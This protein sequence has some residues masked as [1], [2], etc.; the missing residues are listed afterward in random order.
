MQYYQFI[1]GMPGNMYHKNYM[2]FMKNLLNYLKFV[3][4]IMVTKFSIFLIKDMD[5]IN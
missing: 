1:Y 2:S 5:R 4:M 3:I